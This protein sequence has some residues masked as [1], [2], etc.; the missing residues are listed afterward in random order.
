MH[1]P[2]AFYLLEKRDK[3]GRGGEVTRGGRALRIGSKITIGYVPL[4]DCAPLVVALEMGLFKK[5]GFDVHLSPEPGWATIRGKIVYEELDFA[6]AVC[7]LPLVLNYGLKSIPYRCSTAFVLNLNGNAIT[8]SKKYSSI[9]ENEPF[10][11]YG[12]ILKATS[13]LPLL[14]GVA[15]TF[16][17]HYFLLLRWLQKIGLNPQ[18]DIRFVPL[19]PPQM[20]LHLKEGFIDGFCVGEPWNSVSLFEK[21]G[22]CVATSLDL[23]PRH[24]EK[25]LLANAKYKERKREEHIRIVGS[26][27]EACQWADSPL[28][29]QALAEMLHYGGWIAQP[30]EVLRHSLIGPFRMGKNIFIPGQAFHV[31]SQGNANSPSKEKEQWIVNEMVDAGVLKIGERKNQ[32]FFDPEIYKQAEKI[33]AQ[34]KANTLPI[35]I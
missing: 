26:L 13:A 28:N 11:N 14:F 21:T 1:P 33:V 31:F 10:E 18:K 29:R 34:Q 20:P 22:Y 5:W 6:Q 30:L 15:S 25:V 19:P 12:R 23:A 24:P 32:S 4:I 3:V 35:S 17:S 16:S 9:L 7:G 8:L 2:L 27:I